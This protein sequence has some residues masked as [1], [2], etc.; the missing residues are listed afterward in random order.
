MAAVKAL[1]WR[2]ARRGGH[3]ARKS[4]RH[5]FV[6]GCLCLIGGLQI[7]GP[8]L[9]RGQETP[10]RIKLPEIVVLVEEEE[11]LR[12]E[13]T[14]VS[15]PEILTGMELRPITPQSV[16]RRRADRAYALSEKSPP[17]VPRPLDCF[18]SP[19]LSGAAKSSRGAPAFYHRGIFLFLEGN[20]EEARV[21]FEDGLK[22]EVTTDVAARLRYWQGEARFQLGDLDG[23]VQAW[24]EVASD[25]LLPFSGDALY[26][27]GW[28]AFSQEDY[29]EALRLLERLLNRYPSH[30]LRAQALFLAGES[31][32]EVGKPNRAN[33]HLQE[34]VDLAPN[35]FEGLHASY[36][37]G[38]ILLDNER[39]REAVDAYRKYL[40]RSD[41]DLPYLGS[42][43]RGLAWSLFSAGEYEASAEAFSEYIRGEAA[44]TDVLE[45]RFGRLVSL[46]K[47]GNQAEAEAELL[48]LQE[49]DPKNPW[50]LRAG[51]F[52]GARLFQEQDYRGAAATIQPLLSQTPEAIGERERDVARVLLSASLYG[53]GDYEASAHIFQETSQE[54]EAPGAED[55]AF[56]LIWARLQLGDANG[57]AKAAE[58]F[59][60]RFPSSQRLEEVTFWKGEALLRLDRYEAARSALEQVPASHPRYAEATLG[61]GWTHFG[62]G[63]WLDAREAFRRASRLSVRAPALLGQSVFQEGESS[64]NLK[65]YDA[66]IGAYEALLQDLPEHPLADEATFRLG[67]FHY[68][69]GEFEAAAEEFTTFLA[70]PTKSAPDRGHYWLGLSRLRARQ[71]SLAR[72]SFQ[73]LA[74]DFPGSM[75]REDA[76]LRIGH[77]Y[78][79]EGRLD[80]AA[81]AYRSL[82]DET[83]R[84]ERAR[85]AHYGIALTRLRSGD[86]A[87]FVGEARDFIT[88]NQDHPLAVT[89]EFQLAEHFLSQQQY[90]E[91]GESYARVLAHQASQELADSAQFRIGEI[92]SLLGRHPQA[93]AL[94]RDLIA[95][96]P[97][98]RL[99]GDARLRLAQALSASGDCLGAL[100]EFLLFL[101]A[102]P[103]HGL[104][105][106]ALFDAG[107]CAR[108]LGDEEAAHEFFSTLVGRESSGVLTAQ[109][110]WE[111]AQMAKARGELQIAIQ[112]IEKALE[113][114]GRELQPR[115]QF[116]LGEILESREDPRQA[117]VE[118]LKVVYLYPGRRVLNDRALIRVGE[119][120]EKL[121]E[122]DQAVKIYQKLKTESEDPAVRQQAQDRIG[123]L[124][125][126]SP[127]AGGENSP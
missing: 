54:E 69:K 98:S 70:R 4:F 9:A 84:E 117:I 75:L 39:Y 76:L 100:D 97:E 36:R 26:S 35:S 46:L 91:A 118:Y 122:G 107:T 3:Q 15:P 106:R 37:L 50:S 21:E 62:E 27:L 85:E 115:A 93:A 23:A 77:A 89:L 52:L 41:A 19:F 110:H 24:Q 56:W 88:G 13:R 38:E 103:R 53:A 17:V 16:P 104:F 25:T 60:V 66:A 32:L 48:S 33:M 61:L 105:V 111:L 29:A 8:D 87:G 90:E 11:T 94:F 43:R 34:T 55:A 83:P 2:R 99:R 49:A 1:L 18:G 7:L 5:F 101:R 112:H 113:G 63:K 74:R 119:I 72:I 14:P 65:D 51:L 127:P 78:Y 10:L 31:A 6:G 57:A 28:V 116:A 108:H 20:L 59:Q 45:A 92:E 95:Q 30:D 86:V 47:T 123:T 67:I 42:S 125:G 71:Y 102:F 64:L 12:G 22:Q 44:G 109:S 68:R 79:N 114:G 120:Y 58:E 121:G 81:K 126:Q 96:F 80:E 124:G 82:L 40:R 73:R